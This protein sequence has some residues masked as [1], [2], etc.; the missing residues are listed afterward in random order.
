MKNIVFILLICSAS[1]FAQ[2]KTSSAS[3]DD[4]Y[5][6]LKFRN[7]GPAFTSGRIAD[8]AIHP[9]NH[10][11]WYVAVGSGGVWK[12]A[13]AGVTWTPVFDSQP[14][15][16]IG[17]IS[18]DP[19]NPN[20]VWVGT[21]ED[22]GGRHVG[23]GDGVYKSTDGGQHWEHMGLQASEHIARIII[24][25][26]HSDVVYVAAQGPLW[27]KGGERGI[28]K[29]VDGGEHWKR[30]LGD[31][32][33][34]GAADLVIDPRDPDWI[35]AATWQR[36]RTVAAYMGG[37]PGSGIHRSRDG[38]ET[39]EKLTRGIPTSNLGKI[40][41]AISPQDPDVVYAAI[42]LDR[43]TGGVFM[44]S[45]RGTTWVKQSN[46]VSGATGPHYYQELYA[47]PHAA[48][49]IYLMDVRT[50]VSDDHGKTFRRLKEERKHSDNHAMAFREDD[51]DYLLIGTD[52]GIYESFDGAET[53][54]FIG[55]LPVTQYYK[56]A[57]DDSEPFY[58][59]YGGTQDNG[60]HGGPSRTDNE[61]GI[62]NADWFKILGADGHQAAT[63]PGNPH[64][65]YAE[66]QQGGLHRI[67]RIT[68]EQV[69]IMPQPGE[70]EGPERFNW[71]SPVLVSPHNPA[72]IYFASHR[73]WRS[74][75]RGDSWTCISG[76]L[77][78][79]QERMSLPIMGR[80]QGWDNP[81]DLNA[82]SAYNTI[83]SLAESPIQEGLIYVGTDD[84]LIQ[85][86]ED[87]GQNWRSVEIGSIKGIPATA[88][89]NDIRT[90]LFD[91]MTVYAALDNHKF[92]DFKPY[93]LKSMD[94]GRSWN[95]IG[96]DLPE[97]LLVWRLVQDH[98][99][100]DLLFAATEY[101]IYFTP[102]G[103]NKWIKLEGGLP[104]ISFRDLTIQRRENDLVCAS[105]GRGF[106]ILDDYSPLREATASGLPDEAV[107]F[108]VKDAWL[109]VPKSILGGSGAS[110][111]TAENPPFGAIFS[112]YLPADI[113]SLKSQRQQKEKEL[114]EENQD[115]PFPG[116]EALDAEKQ[117][118]APQIRLTIKDV[119]GNLVNTIVGKTS[120]GIHRVNWDLRYASKR[121]I[122]WGEEGASRGPMIIPGTYTVDLAKVVDGKLTELAG[123]RRFEVKQ[124]HR[125]SL[126]GASR[127]EKT[128]FKSALEAFQQD[129]LATSLV[130]DKSVKRIKAMQAAVVRLDREAREL[131]LRI[132]GT[133]E[134][135]KDLHSLMHGS[136][137]AGEVG[138]SG[139][140][141]PGRR[142]SVAENGLATTY[143]PTEMHR[144]SL[145]TGKSELA[146]IKEELAA[147]M[148][149][150]LP[151][152]EKDLKEAGAPWIEGQGLIKE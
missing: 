88:F 26:V 24:H 77:T 19:N 14:V 136:P 66:T 142:L 126:P 146:K 21:G 50:Q 139:P 95:S 52:G 25:P 104:T 99:K 39:W 114:N 130:L 49:R 116:W 36:H 20:T 145:E 69:L 133:A 138:E 15:Y 41:L 90:D 13:N 9:E 129:V 32:D 65:V 16:S 63:E 103:G 58:F 147:I 131:E 82:M 59:I 122:R 149:V 30:V 78:R 22:V 151:Q 54:R 73:V 4:V 1:L 51:P 111:Y 38:G 127:E 7:I 113:P 53:W 152:L 12:T 112:Y 80:Q 70:G 34:T 61:Q 121:G 42:E 124:L 120:K 5:A 101:G 29:S 3:P 67:D 98:L 56:L 48:G 86:T 47:S 6:G 143:G 91:A 81:W 85:V 33:W 27:K 71:D 74:D 28:Y 83:T 97:K 72:R 96:G 107:L 128:A 105:F 84:G 148:E 150:V 94:A 57:V 55:N 18:I 109:Y 79:D 37:G 106:F 140:P 135:L 108:P 125:G 110:C 44:S 123:P 75:D 141:T 89:V 35:Y 119:Q 100:K 132:H 2:D 23:I 45:D 93:V 62:S 118:E 76:D 10:N 17:C 117:Q 40:G 102:D 60:S 92:G 68:G 134:Q 31:D 11:I 64:I 115:I 8:I 144:Q 87:G 137:S 46:T 43:R